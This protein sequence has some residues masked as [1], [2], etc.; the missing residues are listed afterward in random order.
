MA[1]YGVY[2]VKYDNEHSKIK[3]VHAYKVED[4]S[5]KG[6]NIFSRDTVISKIEGND[7][8]FTLLKKSDGNY[9]LKKAIKEIME[10]DDKEKNQDILKKFGLENLKFWYCINNKRCDIINLQISLLMMSEH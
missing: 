10:N 9:R 1:D 4:N 5:T 8:F 6:S 7:K 2:E 3:E